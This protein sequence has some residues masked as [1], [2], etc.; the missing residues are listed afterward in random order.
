ML[1]AMY[2]KLL[3]IPIEGEIQKMVLSIP[4]TSRKIEKVSNFWHSWRRVEI[5][6][7]ILNFY[8]IKRLLQI[9]QT[10]IQKYT[11]KTFEFSHKK[12]PILQF[13]K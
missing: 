6:Y 8:L 2:L 11:E 7:L 3:I 5:Q 4:T 10:D 1:E 13:K 12:T 9:T